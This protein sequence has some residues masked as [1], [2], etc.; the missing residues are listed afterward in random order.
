MRILQPFQQAGGYP[1]AVMSVEVERPTVGFGSLVKQ[2][3]K[4]QPVAGDAVS[5]LEQQLA[6]I[7]IPTRSEIYQLNDTGKD[8]DEIAKNGTFS[9][10]LP[11]SAAVDGM[12][13]YHFRFAYPAGSCTAHR[14]LKHSLYVAVKVSPEASNV[15]VGTATASGGGKLYPVKMTPRDV[16][17]NVVGPVM[18]RG[19]SAPPLRLRQQ[20]RG[21]SQQRQL[22]IR[23]WRRP[24]WTSSC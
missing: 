5:G 16:L 6:K 9:A 4:A 8:G 20:R 22:P 21:R 3:D 14:E 11:I 23:C 10:E 15:V 17:G 12:Y 24:G 19:R 18:R 2:V 13:T 1:G 7:R